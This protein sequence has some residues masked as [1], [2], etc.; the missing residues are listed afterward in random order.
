MER[1]AGEGEEV[2]WSEAG[3]GAVR[4]PL[5]TKEAGVGGDVAEGGEIAG[6]GI[7]A[8]VLGIAAVEVLG[9]Q[10]MQ[11]EAEVLSALAVVG[12]GGAELGRPAEVEEVIVEVL[13]ACCGGDGAGLPGG[14]LRTRSRGWRWRLRRVAAGE[15]EKQEEDGRAGD[16]LHD[17][18][19]LAAFFALDVDV[20][21]WQREGQA[22]V[23][24]PALR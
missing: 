8:A 14:T 23:E 5:V 19:S 3:A 22:P 10:A 13:R 9:P 20:S 18:S 17:A 2:V 21:L 6:C 12:V 15:C 16:V 11:D 1:L 24:M 7:A 4:R